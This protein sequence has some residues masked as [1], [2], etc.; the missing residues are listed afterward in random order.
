MSVSYGSGKKGKAT[1]LHAAIIRAI[2][3][4]EHCGG[5]NVLQ[6]AHIISRRYTAT[7]TDL[8]NAFCLCA[9]CH[10]YFTD[11]P[12]AFGRFVDKRIGRKLYDKLNK[13]AHA[14]AKGNDE[15]WE[16]RIL[17]LQDIGDRIAEEEMTLDEARL[18]E[19]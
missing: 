9:A 13:L 17:F 10:R 18:Y 14:G 11:H 3:A 8:R 12:V 1:K 2:G 16:D 7:R 19:S 4:C 5:D 6:C 15:F